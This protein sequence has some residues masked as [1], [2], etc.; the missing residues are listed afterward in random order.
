MAGRLVIVDFDGFEVAEAPTIDDAV[1]ALRHL[2]AEEH[3]PLRL[4][5]E[6]VD[7]DHSWVAECSGA[8]T[9]TSAGRIEA[10]RREGR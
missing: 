3:R 7:G 8:T 6:D 2:V 10:L 5:L 4:V 1:F 9:V